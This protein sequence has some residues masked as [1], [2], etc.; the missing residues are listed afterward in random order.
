[1]VQKH[2]GHKG[3]TLCPV[4]SGASASWELQDTAGREADT[5]GDICFCCPSCLPLSFSQREKKQLSGDFCGGK[6]IPQAG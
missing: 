1:M 6:N 5:P 3:H 4:C 2:L